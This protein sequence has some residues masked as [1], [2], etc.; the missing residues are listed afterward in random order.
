LQEEEHL[1]DEGAETEGKMW[2]SRWRNRYCKSGSFWQEGNRGE[3]ELATAW[4][5]RLRKT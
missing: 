2:P 1:E 4:G 3:L 5:L